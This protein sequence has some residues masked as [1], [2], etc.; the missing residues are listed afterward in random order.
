MLKPTLTVF[1]FF[2]GIAFISVGCVTISEV[3][4]DID[5]GLGASLILCSAVLAIIGV[6]KK[7]RE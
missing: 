4:L 1:I 3:W 7:M 6:I 2:I 5:I